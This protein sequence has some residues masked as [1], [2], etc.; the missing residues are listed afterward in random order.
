MSDLKEVLIN[1]VKI[2]RAKL[3]A[4][5]CNNSIA[6]FCLKGGV[7]RDINQRILHVFA[8]Q[9]LVFQSS[10]T[11]MSGWTMIFVLGAP[12]SSDPY[13]KFGTK[14]SAHT[15]FKSPIMSVT[16]VCVLIQFDVQ[17]RA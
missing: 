10:Q 5:S 4:H 12:S 6:H 7:E 16:A 14:I 11:A 1:L 15:A 13:Q 8:A 17:S 9:N 2:G 3:P